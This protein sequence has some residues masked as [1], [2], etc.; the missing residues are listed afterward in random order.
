V[1]F[2]NRAITSAEVSSLYS[3]SSISNHKLFGSWLLADNYNDAAQFSYNGT[4]SGTY[5]NIVDD[6]VMAAVRAQ[7]TAST[8][9]WLSADL[10]GG[11][12]LVANIQ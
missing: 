5:F 7:R 9:K 11:Q 3:G 10:T 12:M 8:D 4:S 6:A 1:R 2:Y